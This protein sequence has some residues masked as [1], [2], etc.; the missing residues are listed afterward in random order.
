MPLFWCLHQ[1]LSPDPFPRFKN[2]VEELEQERIT[3]RE[4]DQVLTA[5]LS[6]VE[7]QLGLKVMWE[8]C[9]SFRKC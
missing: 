1:K 7:S 9:Q 2:R 3:L 4:R 6:S 8:D 5:K